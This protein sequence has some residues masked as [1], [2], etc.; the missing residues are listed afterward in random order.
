MYHNG[1]SEPF[2]GK[3]LKNYDRESFY[4][5]TKFPGYDLSNMGKVEEIFEKQRIETPVMDDNNKMN[6]NEEGEVDRRAERFH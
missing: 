1:E 5:A 4:L 6:N 2:V 3:A